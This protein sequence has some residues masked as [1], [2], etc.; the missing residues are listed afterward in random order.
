MFPSDAATEWLEADGLGGFA[1]GP[2]AFARTRRYH[3]LLLRAAGSP[4]NRFVLVNGLDAFVGTG[5]ARAPLSAQ[6]YLPGVTSPDGAGNLAS[7][8]SEP[9]PTWVFSLPDGRAVRQEVFVVRGPAATVVTW[10]LLGDPAGLPLEVRPFFSG[11]DLHSTHHEN[12]GFRFEP[13]RAGNLLRWHPYPG[14]P[15]VTLKT[16]GSYS[17]EPQW[18]RQFL[19]E[20][21]Q[22]RG[23]DDSEDLAAPGVF[24]W[25]LGDGPAVMIL[26]APMPGE[27]YSDLNRDGAAAV[28][29]GWRKGELARRASYA[30][31][32]HRAADEYI[33][34]RGPGHTIIAGYPWF[35]DWG[36]DT[37]ISLRGICLATGRL[38]AARSILLAWSGVVSEGMMP[39]FFP[40]GAGEPEYNSVDASLWYVVAVHDYIDAS[41][42]AGRPVTNGE[43]GCL[44]GAVEAIV[45]GYARGTRFGIGADEDGLLRA[46]HAG[47]QLTWMDAK[48]GDWVVTPRVG[49]PVEVQ[50]LWINALR[51]AAKFNPDWI[52]AAERASRAFLLRFWNEAGGCLYDVVD[53]DHHRGRKD[54]SVRPNQIFAVGGLPFALLSGERA[55]SVLRVVEERLLTPLGLRS[56]DPSHSDYKAHYAGGVRERDGAYHQGTVWPW[57]IGPFAEAWLRVKGNSPTN[58]AAVRERVLPPLHAHLKTAGLGHV[59]EVADGDEPH[60]PGG[61]PFQAWSLAELIR[62]EYGVLRETPPKA[63]R[64]PRTVPSRT[65][66]PG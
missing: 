11:R 10:T 55:A 43:L 52:D 66:R 18:Y 22:A 34:R 59:S 64:Q 19:Y 57:L 50:A 51:I 39:N 4:S 2:V 21:E 37:F 54:P 38:D 33:V 7:F 48:V 60:T 46:G 24:T 25:N 5:S 32:L 36:R 16:N 65:T 62:L 47:V 63:L 31:P 15:S 49:K 53:A 6:R 41:L 9:W 29:A 13:E 40:D 17:H 14:V 12:D 42:K 56:L 26:A 28:A 44:L 35:T 1:S 58:R 61:C 20:A 27:D 30:S 23:L 3:A 8:A 45:G